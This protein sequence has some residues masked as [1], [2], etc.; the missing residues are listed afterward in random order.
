MF[1]KNTVDAEPAAA[2]TNAV[3]L[4]PATREPFSNP[5][6]VTKVPIPAGNCVLPT[7][8]CGSVEL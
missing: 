3:V 8:L 4:I 7:P 6:T 1:D 2:A 5:L